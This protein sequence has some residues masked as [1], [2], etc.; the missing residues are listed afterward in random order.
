MIEGC[1]ASLFNGPVDELSVFRWLAATLY[2]RLLAPTKAPQLPEP[3]SVFLVWRQLYA[4]EK[5][6]AGICR[7]RRPFSLSTLGSAYAVELIR[8]CRCHGGL[9]GLP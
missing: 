7:N 1:G 5:V 3:L 8:A 2:V 4:E 9:R 6:V